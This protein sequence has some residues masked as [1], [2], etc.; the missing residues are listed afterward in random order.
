[1]PANLH[2]NAITGP[3]TV[4][5]TTETVAITLTPFNTNNPGGEGVALNGMINMLAGASVTGINVK[6]YRAAAGAPGVVG[7]AVPAGATQ[8]GATLLQTIAAA[9][10]GSL[11]LNAL[12]PSAAALLGTG[13]QWF[14]TVTQVAATGNGTINYSVMD[15]QSCTAVE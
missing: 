3:T 10:T 4:T 1:M 6:V 15:A 12:D 7:A 2:C 8:V 9:A 11:S 13:Q 14:A 5:T